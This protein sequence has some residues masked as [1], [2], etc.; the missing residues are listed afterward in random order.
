MRISHIYALER[1]KLVLAWSFNSK[2]LDQH[3]LTVRVLEHLVGSKKVPDYCIV[4]D[5]S[6]N[7]GFILCPDE[8]KTS[9]LRGHYVKVGDEK[10]FNVVSNTGC[11]PFLEDVNQHPIGK[12]MICFLVLKT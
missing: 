7:Y 11:L 9:R 12:K 6:C 8:D 4:V 2:V 1:V 5:P 3:M 10:I